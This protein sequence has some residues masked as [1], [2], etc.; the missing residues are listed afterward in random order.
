MRCDQPIVRFEM[1]NCEAALLAEI[2]DTCF[3]RADVAITYSLA[4]RSSE[5]IDWEKVNCAIIAR[6]SQSALNWIKREAWKL[7]GSKP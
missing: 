4:L 6:W 7:A 5:Q 3:K 2:G 1:V